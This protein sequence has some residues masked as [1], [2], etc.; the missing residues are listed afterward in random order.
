MIRTLIIEDEKPAA[1]RLKR[2][3]ISLDPDIEI[4][5]IIETVESA[6]KWFESHPHPDLI[7]LDIQLGD[8]LS[9]DIFRKIKVDS[10]A[11]FTTAFDEYAI[12]AFELNSI[13]YLLKPVDE[14]KLLQSLQK[15]RKFQSFSQTVNIG[16]LLDT[17]EIRKDKFKKRFVVSIANKIKVIDTGAVAYFYS[18]EKSTFL[19]TMDN[20]HFPLEFSLD[21]VEQILDPEWFFRLSRQYIVQYRSITKIDIL[22]KSRIRIETNPPAG[23]EMLVSSARTAD[24]RLWL[25]R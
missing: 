13:D 10:Y 2:L 1:L 19:C 3:L 17:I 18:K 11:I 21:Y 22:S 5:G 14:T 15:F 16:K 6:V 4:L 23:E 9:F 20:R 24:F 25:D 8:G 12:K 7:M